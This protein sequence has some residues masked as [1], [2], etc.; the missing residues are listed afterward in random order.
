[1]EKY[2]IADFDKYEEIDDR[3]IGTSIS[4]WEPNCIEAE[5]GH[6][7]MY[8]RDSH[9]PFM[10]VAESYDYGRTWTHQ[11]NTSL[12]NGN[13]K[14]DMF[15]INS[16]IY[17]VA[18]ISQTLTWDGRTKLQ[19]LSSR[20]NAKSWNFVCYVS[21]PDEHF[22]Y[23]HSYVDYE[24]KLVYLAYENA[25]QHYINVYTFEELGV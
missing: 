14:I 18:N 10:N 17:L 7:I 5:N 24:K 3:N 23:P 11:G 20:D 8:M 4:L 12:P 2:L 13:S 21:E 6:I 25:R 9:K 15:K 22:F 1:M 19:I 16:T